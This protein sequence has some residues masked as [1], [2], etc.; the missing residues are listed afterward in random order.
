MRKKAKKNKEQ[1]TKGRRTIKTSAVSTDVMFPEIRKI[2]EEEGLLV[3]KNGRLELE[4]EVKEKILKAFKGKHSVK[5]TSPRILGIREGEDSADRRLTQAAVK[6]I[7]EECKLKAS[8]EAEEEIS[9]PFEKKPPLASAEVL[10]VRNSDYALALNYS[11]GMIPTVIAKAK[12]SEAIKLIRQA[13][14]SDIPVVEVVNWDISNFNQI[15]IGK[16]IPENIYAI[17]A[18]TLAL[19]Y[20]IRPDANF[21]RFI[22]PETKQDI[23]LKKKSKALVAARK[24]LLDVPMLTAELSEMLYRHKNALAEQLQNDVRKLT[25]ETGIPVPDVEIV[26][27]DHLKEYEYV[28]KI[29]GV[30]YDA[31]E[32][33]AELAPPELFFNLQNKFRWMIYAYGFELLGYS[34]VEALVENLKKKKPSLVKALFPKQITIGALRFILREL[35][36]EQVPIIDLST[37]LETIEGSLQN[38][39]DPEVLIEYVRSAFSHYITNSQKDSDGSLNV[40]LLSPKTEEFIAGSIRESM[41]V[42]W[43]DLDYSDGLGLLS[44]LA[45]E[46]KKLESLKIPVVILTSPPIRRFI[47]KIT[48][49][50]FPTLPVMSYSEVAPMTHVKTVGVIDLKK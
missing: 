45:A 2:V 12:K 50:S 22:K 30:S 37:I 26:K 21:V 4:E 28:L 49:P 23:N 32:L 6:V 38:T 19:V 24:S 13:H 41:N 1:A 47:R 18:K 16:E 43:M 40:I 3:E 31:G 36:R 33:K 46:L 17:A 42:R 8:H 35:L 7:E 34:E 14:A 11:P 15:E 48:Q 9:K 39:G 10:M 5:S 20:K 29:K 44:S 25:S 27:S